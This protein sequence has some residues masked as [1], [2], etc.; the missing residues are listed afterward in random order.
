MK[1]ALKNS[2]AVIAVAAGKGGP[3]KSTT[4]LNTAVGF[5]QDGLTVVI[6]ELDPQGS[7]E[8][9]QNVR[10][11]NAVDVPV[12]LV[13]AHRLEQAVNAL[14][15][16][17]VD[18]IVIDTPPSGSAI[19]TAAVK[20]ADLVLVPT[21]P[22]FFDSL[23]INPTVEV[24]KAVPGG[25]EKARVVIN[26][27]IGGEDRAQEAEEAILESYGIK[28]ISRL[29]SRVAFFDSLSLGLGVTEYA[30]RSKAAKEVRA[31]VSAIKGEL[32]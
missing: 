31:L 6:L 12:Q 13:P 32:A 19:A 21:R 25:I 18:L 9:W 29:G 1:Q 8:K 5:A 30:P 23:G 24:L 15:E 11:D 26:Q 14:K 4:A 7:L 16:A 2:T 17:A 3:G 10:G 20:V 22:A 28:T 27:V